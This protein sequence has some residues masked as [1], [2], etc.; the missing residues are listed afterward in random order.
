MIQKY[1]LAKE[2]IS[3]EHKLG[4]ALCVAALIFIGISDRFETA[5]RDLSMTETARVIERKTYNQLFILEKNCTS[6][7][8]H[9]SVKAGLEKENCKFPIDL[10]N[11][12]IIESVCRSKVSGMTPEQLGA[13]AAV[14]IEGIAKHM[15]NSFVRNPAHENA[16]DEP[17]TKSAGV[18]DY[19]HRHR[20]ISSPN[21]VRQVILDSVT[22]LEQVTEE[23]NLDRLDSLEGLVQNALDNEYSTNCFPKDGLGATV[24]VIDTGCRAD[25]DELIGRTSQYS[26]R[27]SSAEDDNGHGSHIASIAAGTIYGVCKKCQ[28]VCIKAL[29]SE[30]VGTMSDVLDAMNWI[31]D[32]HREKADDMPGVAVLSLAA[33]IDIGTTQSETF[34]TGIDAMVS[35]GVVPV[36][37]AGN[38]D[39]SDACLYS[40]AQVESAVTVGGTN[41]E[42][43]PYS[44]GNL[45]KCVDVVAPGETINSAW[46]TS[47]SG[48]NSQELSN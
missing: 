8:C 15:P 46:F 1:L 19:K 7:A 17:K 48:T 25:H 24:Y 14:N 32:T 23:W 9:E 6:E 4:L 47:K 27:F 18:L 3:V 41:I 37:A 36:V 26:V 12:R 38:N 42:D 31:V 13:R 11:L 40:P 34:K 21:G 39:K 29:D 10:R 28:I 2:M 22:R 35:V 16:Q 5:P 43:K 44:R 30:G 33:R 20:S 45:G